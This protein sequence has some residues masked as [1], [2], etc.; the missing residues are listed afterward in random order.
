MAAG[1]DSNVFIKLE[2]K[3]IGAGVVPVMNRVVQVGAVVCVAMVMI[4]STCVIKPIN[5]GVTGH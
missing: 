2:S 1:G 3:L 4:C 5:P